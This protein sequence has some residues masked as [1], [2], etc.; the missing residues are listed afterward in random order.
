[1]LL[2]EGDSLGDLAVHGDEPE[3]VPNEHGDLFLLQK[4]GGLDEKVQ[5]DVL[6]VKAHG[7]SG[8]IVLVPFGD[9]Q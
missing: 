4:K 9:V 2:H 3:V 8:I 1:M 6:G 5:G 7:G